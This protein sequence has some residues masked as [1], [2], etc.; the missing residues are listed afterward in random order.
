[1]QTETLPIL[2]LGFVLGLKHAL[3]ADHLIA[4]ATI[5]SERRGIFRSSVVGLLWGLGHTAALLVVGCGVVALHLQIPERVA[6]GMEFAVAAMLIAL[7]A[8]VLWKLWRG[9]TLHVHVHAHHGRT[10]IHPHTHAWMHAHDHS[11]NAS[12][13]HSWAERIVERA[14]AHVA[15]N[16]RS[17]LVGMVHGVAGSAALMLIVLATI[18]SPVVGLMYIAVFG[19]G[20]VG[21][22]VAMSTLVGMPLT[23]VTKGAGGAQKIFRAIAG[24]VSVIFG[25]LLAYRIGFVEGLFIR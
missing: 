24:S 11:D 1:M 25:L 7:G 4:V 18:P 3:D 20:S 13:H 9:E 17:L 14:C 12:H 5:L 23:A 8:A 22:M 16:K 6:L 19:L 10:H 2:G 15:D 21:G